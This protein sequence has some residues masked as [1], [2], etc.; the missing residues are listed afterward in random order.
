[1]KVVMEFG[2]E[3]VKK[4]LETQHE[5][6]GNPELDKKVILIRLEV[7]FRGDPVDVVFSREYVTDLYEAAIQNN[8]KYVKIE[9]NAPSE[10][11]FKDAGY[12]RDGH[13]YVKDDQPN[14]S[15]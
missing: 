7:D 8:E 4:A 15:N 3:K 11:D 12:K 5:I 9:Y 14:Q 13:F 1:M 2:V 10:Q 6:T